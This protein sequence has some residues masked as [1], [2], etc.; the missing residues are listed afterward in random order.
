MTIQVTEVRAAEIQKGRCD[1]EIE[2]PSMVCILNFGLQCSALRDGGTFR[3]QGLVAL[4]IH[5]G[6]R[7]WGTAPSFFA[8]LH[9]PHHCHPAL[10]SYNSNGATGYRLELPVPGAKKPFLFVT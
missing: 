2:C 9:S 1:L 4:R 3:R 5:W 6:G 7:L 8:P 10:Q